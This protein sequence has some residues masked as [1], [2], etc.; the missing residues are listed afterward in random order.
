LA[1][2]APRSSVPVWKEYHLNNSLSN[3]EALKALLFQFKRKL[4]GRQPI[5]SRYDSVY[6]RERPID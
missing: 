5:H 1:V 6:Y 4:V 2:T 3:Y